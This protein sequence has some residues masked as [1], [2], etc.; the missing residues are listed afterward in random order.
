MFLFISHGVWRAALDVSGW[1]AVW[2]NICG[3]VD[4]TSEVVLLCFVVCLMTWTLILIS[5]DKLFPLVWCNEAFR[6][7]VVFLL[8]NAWSRRQL[9]SGDA[10]LW[11]LLKVFRKYYNKTFP[12]SGVKERSDTRRCRAQSHTE[13]VCVLLSS[14]LFVFKSSWVEDHT[15]LHRP[16]LTYFLVSLQM[17]LDLICQQKKWIWEFFNEFSRIIKSKLPI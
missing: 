5:N 7:A 11:F 14:G 13:K 15:T 10:F 12:A 3:L 1:V 4:Y 8:L 16:H 9:Q 6:S 17:C 2:P